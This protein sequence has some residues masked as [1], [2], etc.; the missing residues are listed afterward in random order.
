M[1]SKKNVCKLIP[2]SNRNVAWDEVFGDDDVDKNIMH[3]L[4]FNK[5]GFV[6][7]YKPN[8]TYS[9]SANYDPWAFTHTNYEYHSW[10]NSTVN[11][12]MID[13]IFTAQTENDAKYMLGAMHFLRSSTKGYFGDNTENELDNQNRGTP[14][15]VLRFH[16][17]GDHMFN[18]VPVI[19]K[20]FSFTVENNI[21]HVPIQVRG[22]VSYVPVQ[23]NIA[24]VVTIQPN[25]KNVKSEFSLTKF[26][27]GDLLNKGYL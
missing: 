14:P 8:V 15:P 11:D 27:N 2:Y 3:P 24:M 4:R 22:E 6:Y 7:P 5:T 13:G 23:M 26:R 25:P 12:I 9:G 16:Y 10:Q 1:E 19:I 18:G 21:D 17:L 20:N